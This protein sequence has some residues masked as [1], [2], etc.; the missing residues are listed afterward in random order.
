TID[1]VRMDSILHRRA[2]K[3][4]RAR[5]ER[6]G[7]ARAS[8]PVRIPADTSA[9]QLGRLCLP[10]RWNNVT[11]GYLWFLDDEERVTAAQA[12]EA[13]HLCD[14]AGLEMARRARE[15]DDLGLKLAD[16]LSPHPDVRA[17]AADDLT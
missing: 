5:F 10:V 13:M 3:D 9:G 7:I 8:G 1:P 2:S 15:R 12:E 16:L 6:Y 11:Y 14:R 4:V 17:Q